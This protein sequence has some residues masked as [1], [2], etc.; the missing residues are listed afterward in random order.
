MRLFRWLRAH[1]KLTLVIIIILAIGF[2]VL[3]ARAS[4]NGATQEATVERG[5]VE[6]ELVLTGEISATDYAS[7]QF[8][9][10][11]TVSWVGVKVGEEVKKGQALMKLDTVKLNALYQA[12]RANYRAAEANAQEVL[13]DVKGNDSGETFAQ[14]ND[15]TAAETA[16]D[17]AWDALMSAQKDL[18]DATL[19][20]PFDGVVAIVNSESPGVNITAATPQVAVVNPGTLYFEVLADQTEVAFFGPRDT[21]EIV[22][23]AFDGEAVN[24]TVASVSIAPDAVETGTVYPIRLSLDLTNLLKYKIGM[25]G[26]AKFILSR[27]DDVLYVPADFVNSDGEGDYVL[28]NSGK[29]KKYIEVGIEGEERVE[30]KGD[31]SEGEKVFD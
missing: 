3:R 26:D 19:V 1:K 11:G 24:A 20:A 27:K 23:D 21:A 7:L 25:T 30:I 14:K 17:K 5:T 22:L 9:T 29:D 13:D 16:R 15:R 4:G 2:F 18:Q 6:E 31:I 8:N 28:V 10:S 12:A